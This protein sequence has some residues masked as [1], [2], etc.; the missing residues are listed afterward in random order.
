MYYNSKLNVKYYSGLA[1]STRENSHKHCSR[2]GRFYKNLRKRKNSQNLKS[3][4]NNNNNNNNEN[5]LPGTDSRLS[6]H[7]TSWQSW[8]LATENSLSTI[9]LLF[10]FRWR[11][12]HDLGIFMKIKSRFQNL[13][14]NKNYSTN[15]IFAE[16]KF[17]KLVH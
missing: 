14:W 1:P 12:K 11:K 9:S 15:P 6:S 13:L 3:N 7:K 16:T 10:Q 8:I 2:W 5:C 17:K 4:N